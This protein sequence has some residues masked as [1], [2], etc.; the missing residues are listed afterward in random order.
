MA[1]TKLLELPYEKIA[2]SG[3]QMPDGLYGFDQSMFLR[4]RLLYDTFK[5]G[6]IDRDT[7]QREKRA[8]LENYRWEKFMDNM[9]KNNIKRITETDMARMEYRKN[10]TLENADAVMEAFER[11]PVAINEVEENGKG[12]D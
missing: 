8:L 5:K 1:E 4:L 7:A 3:G 2:M 11:V 6:I 9:L 12:A 10:R